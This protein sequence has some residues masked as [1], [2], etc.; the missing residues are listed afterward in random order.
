MLIVAQVVSEDAQVTWLVRFSVELSDKVPVAVNCSVSPVGRL[1][2]AGVTAIDLRTAAVTV[3]TVEPV[4]PSKVAEIVDGP[5]R[6]AG[7]Q[8]GGGDR[9]D[10]GG[11]RRPGHLAG[12]VLGGVVGQG[13]GGGELLGFARWASWV[14]R[15]HGDRL[16]D[17]GSDRQPRRARDPSN[18]AEIVTGPGAI[19]VARPVLLIVA[20]VVRTRPTVTWLVRFSVELSDMVPVAVNCSVS[21]AGKLVLAGVTAID[22]RTA[23]VAVS[24]VVPVMPSKV[25][26]MVTGPG[27]TEVAS[28]VLL[29]VIHVV[30]R[31]P[32]SPGRSGSRWS[33]RTRYPWR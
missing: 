19:E 21:P 13:A 10:R 17:C 1:V 16:E 26:E 23:A 32:T 30:R 29:T 11:G 25:A 12:Q 3:N 27:E 7:G 5:G 4:M 22:W 2:L 24:P 20:Q 18:V 28:P 6:D 15:R 33:C 31:K 8:T 9:G 14:G